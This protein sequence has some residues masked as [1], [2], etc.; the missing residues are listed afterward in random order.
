MA[1]SKHQFIMGLIVRQMRE[2]GC[3]IMFIDGS[4]IIGGTSGIRIPPQVLRHRPDILGIT[5]GGQI[6]IG[7]AKTEEDLR[8]LRTREQ[9]FDFTSLELNDMPCKVFYGVPSNAKLKFKKILKEMGLNSCPNLH[10]LYIP[11]EIINE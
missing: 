5:D 2:S 11:E 8:S 9:I 1:G 10:V 4:S 3:K 7:E 6:F